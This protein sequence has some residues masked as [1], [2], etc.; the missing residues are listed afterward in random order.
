MPLG[1][2]TCCGIKSKSSFLEQHLLLILPDPFRSRDS[3]A[4]VRSALVLTMVALV[5]K[6]S[7]L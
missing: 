5:T 2:H 6:A 4:K 1:Y 3:A 7:G